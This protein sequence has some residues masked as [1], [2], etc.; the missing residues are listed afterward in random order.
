MIGVSYGTILTLSILSPERH[1]VEEKKSARLFGPKTKI[2]SPDQERRRRTVRPEE[3]VVLE[4]LEKEEGKSAQR[5]RSPF[6][7]ERN[8]TRKETRNER[9]EQ[10]ETKGKSAQSKR[11][12]LFLTPGN[13]LR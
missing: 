4:T 7:F 2:D 11:N 8:E 1:S 3:K 6:V 12:F 10:L 5:K 9:N 13:L